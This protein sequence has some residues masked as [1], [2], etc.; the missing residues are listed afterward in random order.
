MIEAHCLLLHAQ[1]VYQKRTIGHPSENLPD[2]KQQLV[3][4]G[5]LAD[6]Q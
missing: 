4:F 6:L 1:T 2:Q 5:L 3:A